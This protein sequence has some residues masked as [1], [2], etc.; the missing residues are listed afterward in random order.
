MLLYGA[1]PPSPFGGKV[2]PGKLVRPDQFEYFRMA[3]AILRPMSSVQLAS[4]TVVRRRPDINVFSVQFQDYKEFT[5]LCSNRK[6]KQ[7]AVRIQKQYHAPGSFFAKKPETKTVF[8]W[9]TEAFITHTSKI[10]EY[11]RNI[12]SRVSS[13]IVLR[14]HFAALSLPFVSNVEQD[15][16]LLSESAMKAK[17]GVSEILT[18]QLPGQKYLTRLKE[19]MRLLDRPHATEPKT[20][21]HEEPDK[22][23]APTFPPVPVYRRVLPKE[24][25]LKLLHEYRSKWP[26]DVDISSVSTQDSCSTI[27][28]SVHDED[29]DW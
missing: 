25:A 24:D 4:V 2:L 3:T 18:K 10:W 1:F 27:L 20:V 23:Q 28:S 12:I 19:S 15:L 13:V 5:S 11:C 22:R 29:A 8:G 14:R 6:L 9:G 7:S 26:N 16:L 21:K 17:L